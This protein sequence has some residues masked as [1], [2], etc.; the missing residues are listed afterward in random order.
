MTHDLLH[1]DLGAAV[2]DNAFMLVVLPLIALWL[3]VRFGSGRTVMPRPAIATV[4][5][6]GIAWTVIRNSPGFPLVPTLI[7]G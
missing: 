4:I 2:M 7:A 3:A 6:A 5:V 1:G